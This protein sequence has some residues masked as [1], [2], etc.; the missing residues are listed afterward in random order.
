MIKKCLG[1]IANPKYKDVYENVRIL[2]DSYED[3]QL[4][5]A[6]V[7]GIS[8]N[9]NLILQKYPYSGFNCFNRDKMIQGLLPICRLIETKLNNKLKL[10]HS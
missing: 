6:L 7:Q 5:Y 9:E 8:L 4:E 2:I 10:I 1:E 3:Y